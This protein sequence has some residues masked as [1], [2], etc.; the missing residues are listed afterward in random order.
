MRWIKEL[1]NPS[2]KCKRL[3]HNFDVVKIVIRRRSKVPGF[4]CKDY[5]AEQKVCKRCGTKTPPQ[6]EEYKDYWTSVTMPMSMW[7]EMDRKGYLRVD[8]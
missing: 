3:G 2:L 5:F 4:I 1:F 6:N 8:D 7:E